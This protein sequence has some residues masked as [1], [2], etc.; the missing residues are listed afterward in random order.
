MLKV[1]QDFRDVG[2]TILHPVDKYLVR[3][4][5]V[6]LVSLVVIYY[7]GIGIVTVTGVKVTVE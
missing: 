7:N 5:L 4:I 1:D 3:Q 2:V 6:I